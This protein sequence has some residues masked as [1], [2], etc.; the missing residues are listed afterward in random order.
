VSDETQ[1]PREAGHPTS[2][3]APFR[4]SQVSRLKVSHKSMITV[5]RPPPVE[6]GFERFESSI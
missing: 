5:V 4:S 6:K 3:G 2:P 1:T